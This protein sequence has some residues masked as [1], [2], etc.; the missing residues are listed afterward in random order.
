MQELLQNETT[1]EPPS[2]L[3]EGKIHLGN[4]ADLLPCLEDEIKFPT[5][6][7]ISL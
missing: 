3:T 1:R 6:E 4:K 2:L 5:I 7:S